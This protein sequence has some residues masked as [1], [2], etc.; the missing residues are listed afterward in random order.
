MNYRR[1]LEYALISVVAICGRA[2]STPAAGTPIPV[3]TWVKMTT[4][5]VPAQVVGFGRLTYAAGFKRTVMM[6][7]YHQL[8]SEPNEALLAYDF[9]TNRWDVLNLGGNFHMEDMSDGGHSVG[10]LVYNPNQNIFHYYGMFSGSQAL[11]MPLHTWWYDPFGQVGRD[12]HTSPKPGGTMF[13]GGAFDVASNKFVLFSG[14]TFMYDPATNDWSKKTPLGTPPT[15]AGGYPSMDYNSQNKKVYMFGG[16]GTYWN[17]VYSYDVPTNTW[18]HHAPA[19]TP[20]P[21][22]SEAAFAYDSTNNIFLLYGG[23]SPAGTPLNDTWVYDPAAD[24]WTALTPAQSPTPAGFAS[25]GYLAYDAA[26]NAFIMVAPGAGG[27]AGG[28]GT[29]YNAQTWIFRYKGAGPDA[30][31]VDVNPGATP[32]GLNRYPDGWANEPV[33]ASNGAE[34]YRG[35]IET[36]PMWDTT[37]AT[38]PH[39]YASKHDGNAW[40][41]LGGSFLS[42]DSESGGYSESHAPSIALVNGTPWISWQKSNNSSGLGGSLFAKRWNGTAWVGGPVP[43]GSPGSFFT[44]VGRSQMADVAGTPTIAFLENDRDYYP[45]SSHLYVKSWNGSAWAPMGGRLNR[46][47]GTNGR[48]A[49]S[50]SLA[51]DGANPVAAWTEYTTTFGVDTPPQVYV[52]RWNGSAWVAVGGSLNVSP[53]NWAYDVSLAWM[54]GKPYAAWTERSMAGNAQ[55]H[56]KTW[57]GTDWVQVGAGTLNRDVAT[58][59]AYRPSLVADAAA[60]A[61]YVGWVE[62]QALGKKAQVH[63]SKSAGG[64][65]TSLGATLN[66]DPALG[67][68]QRAVV[69]VVQGKPVVAWGEVN[70]GCLRQIYVRQWNGSA[71][72]PLASGGPADTQPPSIPANLFATAVSPDSI[73]LAWDPSTDNVGVATYVVYRDGTQ[74]AT[75]TMP[76]YSDTGLAASTSYVYTVAAVDGAGNGSPASSPAVAATPSSSVP[77]AAAGAPK[78]GGRGCGLL[79]IEALI[80]LV[81]RPRSSRRPPAACGP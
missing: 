10:A 49:E 35:W 8:G 12:K 78:R 68:A 11:E 76:S 77:V 69:A 74:I 67:S 71:W 24:R 9:T 65:W 1:I 48:M 6:E 58:G 62:Q 3:N 28:G 63:L 59:W 72:A 18:T 32:G 37:N 4:K 34:L 60:G 21:P 30:G 44:T 23:M 14:E 66:A 33:L 20:P 52:S 50:V 13:A 43:A 54:G 27:Y 56:V 38:W 47:A 16:Q 42:L 64:A 73:D 53:A 22:R 17:D 5:G 40:N 2:A 29:G 45:W 61:L 81:I 25:F 31:T 26:N 57:N 41:A 39:V 75:T 19:G 15:S 55:L 70:L 36:G 46:S 51:S 7:N 79:G 80:V